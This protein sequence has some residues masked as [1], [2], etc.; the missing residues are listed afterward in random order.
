MNVLMSVRKDIPMRLWHQKLIP[1]L[2][3]QQLLGQHRECCAMRGKF[4]GRKHSVVD[5]VWG[6]PKENLLQYHRLVMDEMHKRGYKV[7]PKWLVSYKHVIGMV[8]KEHNADYLIECIDNLE[9]K[10]VSL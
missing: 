4:W 7:G 5:Y 8:Y 1:L 6:Y 9:S 3:R 10:G 2:P